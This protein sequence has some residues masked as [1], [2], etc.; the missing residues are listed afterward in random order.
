MANAYDPPE[1]PALGDVTQGNGRYDKGIPSV[2]YPPA[3]TVG[4]LPCVTNGEP[5][6]PPTAGRVYYDGFDSRCWTQAGASLP[7]PVPALW[8]RPEGFQPQPNGQQLFSWQ[9]GTPNPYGLFR[10]TIPLTPYVVD[11]WRNGQPSLQFESVRLYALFPTLNLGN[12][13]SI[14]IVYQTQAS[15]GAGMPSLV[16]PV[17]NPTRIPTFNGVSVAFADSLNFITNAY[18]PLAPQFGLI[19]LKKIPTNITITVKGT[20][21]MN[22]A[23]NPLGLAS[24]GRMVTQPPFNYGY[25]IAELLF[26]SPV[27]GTAADTAVQA[28]LNTRYSL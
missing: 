23:T 19:N 27:L 8:F 16:G 20:V 2:P 1:P 10:S 24:F 12:S 4:S 14:Y 7:F 9:N 17:G 28:Y 11:P 6:P 15:P 3:V 13:Y 22:A 26:F 5:Y 21:V 18:V 25:Q